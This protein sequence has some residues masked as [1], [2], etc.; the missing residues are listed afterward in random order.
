MLTNLWF[1]GNPFAICK[2][3]N[4]QFGIM[5]HNLNLDNVICRFYLSKTG[6]G[7]VALSSLDSTVLPQ[8][9]P[10]GHCGSRG[11]HP[12]DA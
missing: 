3:A 12:S 10:C 4:M 11:V 1:F 5:L 2:F 8:S 6:E 7:E 9:W